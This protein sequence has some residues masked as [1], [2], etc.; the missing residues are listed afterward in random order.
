MRMKTG[1]GWAELLPWWRGGIPQLLCRCDEKGLRASIDP[2]K[3]H[4]AFD[5]TLVGVCLKL[6]ST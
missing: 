2:C 4:P 1:S 5:S 6:E 3:G